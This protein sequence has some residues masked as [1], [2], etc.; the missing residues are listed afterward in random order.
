MAEKDRPEAVSSSLEGDEAR[1]RWM[2]KVFMDPAGPILIEDLDG[3]VFDMNI[4]AERSYGWTRGRL[5]GKPILVIVPVE[6]HGQ[7]RDLLEKCKAGEHVRNVEGLR[8]S[9]QVE[10]RSVLLTLSLLRDDEGQPAR[11]GRT[12]GSRTS[13]TP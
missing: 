4:E 3:R 2:S 10:V 5:I 9:K 6:R 7:A 1:L 11:M 8:H 13:K 12:G